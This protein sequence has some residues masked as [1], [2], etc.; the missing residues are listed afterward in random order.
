MGMIGMIAAAPSIG[1][2]GMRMRTMTFK[3]FL[4]HEIHRDP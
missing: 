2:E 3:T 4:I 1:S